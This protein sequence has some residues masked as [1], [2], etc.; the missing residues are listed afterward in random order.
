[1]ISIFYWCSTTKDFSSSFIWSG[2]FNYNW[3]TWS[4]WDS[5]NSDFYEIFDTL[6]I[7]LYFETLSEPLIKLFLEL[8]LFYETY[9]FDGDAVFRESL[10]FENGV[11]VWFFLYLLYSRSFFLFAGMS[12]ILVWFPSP[13]VKLIS[14]WTT[15]S[16]KKLSFVFYKWFMFFSW[17]DDPYSLPIGGSFTKFDFILI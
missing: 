17:I 10:V 7:D 8:L 16:S 13:S 3:K 2:L 12:S 1:M 5:A 11:I 6:F 9:D 4:A 15:V 14:F